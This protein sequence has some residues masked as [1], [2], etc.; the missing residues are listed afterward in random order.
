[1]SG[2]RA[3]SNWVG[4]RTTRKGCRWLVT[5]LNENERPVDRRHSHLFPYNQEMSDLCLQLNRH[6]EMLPS[7][8]SVTRKVAH[9]PLTITVDDWPYDLGGDMP[10]EAP[11]RLEYDEYTTP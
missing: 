8:I 10:T 5:M 4:E 3:H 9:G 2:A 6:L 11:V 7:S 1:M